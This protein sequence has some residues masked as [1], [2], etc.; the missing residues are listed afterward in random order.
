VPEGTLILVP[1]ELERRALFGDSAPAHVRLC[2]FGLAEAGARA[3]HAI[4]T[5]GPLPARVVLVG[6]AGSYDADRF[7][8]GSA[9]VGG[10][11]RLQGIGAGGQTPSGLGFSD[12]DLLPLEGD[13]PEILSVAEASAD[14]AQAGARRTRFP[15]AAVEEMEGF[16]VAVAA[17]AFG[18]PLRVIRGVS[19]LA[20]DRDRDRWQIGESLRAAA[21]ALEALA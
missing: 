4:A 13:G 3:G 5:F 16:A 19:N 11:I 10:S 21:S 17:A 6:I 15:T 20:G 9:V 8:P 7:P 1:T 2:G 18:V 14:A 12:T